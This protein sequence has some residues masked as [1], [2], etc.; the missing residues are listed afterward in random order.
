VGTDCDRATWYLLF[1]LE[2]I[3]QE[4]WEETVKCKLHQLDARYPQGV[5]HHQQTYW[6][7]WML[8]STVPHLG[9][10]QRRATNEE[11]GTQHQAY[12]QAAVPLL[13]RPF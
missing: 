10:L 6:Q 9:K 3:K 4:R 1:R 7:I 8:L 2:Q 12:Q 11:Q 13:R 5:K